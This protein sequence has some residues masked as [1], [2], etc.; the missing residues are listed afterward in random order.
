MKSVFKFLDGKACK[1]EC[2]FGFYGNLTLG[3]CMP[4]SS[5]CQSCS[6]SAT[7]CKTCDITK[8]LRYLMNGTCKAKCDDGHTVPLVESDYVCKACS[9]NCKTCVGKVGFCL[10]CKAEK[11]FLSTADNT[12]HAQCPDGVTVL[13]DAKKKLCSGCSSVCATCS[14]TADFCTSCRKDYS[15][16]VTEKTITGQGTTSKVPVQTCVVDCEGIDVKGRIN[17]LVSVD[18]KCTKCN[19]P[20]D[21]CQERPDKCLTCLA[22]QVMHNF[23]CVDTCPD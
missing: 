19:A 2:P 7:N 6:G 3:K 18:G 21:T 9:D 22:S 5:P 13:T 10:T 23:K 15:L 12:C 17:R 8:D 1:P 16:H 14:G 20:C 11:P 4:C